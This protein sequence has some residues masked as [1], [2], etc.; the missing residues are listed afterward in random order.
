MTRHHFSL[1]ALLA[2]AFAIFAVASAIGLP[3]VAGHQL[4]SSQIADTVFAERQHESELAADSLIG[5]L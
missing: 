1:W 3:E 4:K 5:L 2:A